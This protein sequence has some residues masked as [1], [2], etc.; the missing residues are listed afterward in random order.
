MTQDRPTGIREPR[1]RFGELRSVPCG[2]RQVKSSPYYGSSED[3]L[4]YI[5]SHFCG[6]FLASLW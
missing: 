5:F 4:D 2:H 3:T 6:I 1:H